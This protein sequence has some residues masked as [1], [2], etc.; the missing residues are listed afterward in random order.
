M[1]I[2]HNTQ[3]LWENLEVNEKVHFYSQNFAY[4]SKSK[5]RLVG[6]S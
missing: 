5:I 2:V 6:A 3:T 4:Y 1:S